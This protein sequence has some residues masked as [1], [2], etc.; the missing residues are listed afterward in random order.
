MHKELEIKMAEIWGREE[1]EGLREVLEEAG[2]YNEQLL[3]R[4]IHG[5]KINIVRKNA[6]DHQNYDSILA[7]NHREVYDP[8]SEM[9]ATIFDYADTDT[10]SAIAIYDQSCFTKEQEFYKYNFK[11][12]ENKQEALVAIVNLNWE[13]IF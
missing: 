13:P 3:Y 1:H 7:L 10:P 12:P 4:G 6:T 9:I 8:N 11:N 2:M 5:S